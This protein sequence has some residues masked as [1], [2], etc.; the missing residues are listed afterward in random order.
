M[1]E[2]NERVIITPASMILL[3]KAGMI[4]DV[5]MHIGKIVIT[6][7]TKKITVDMGMKNKKIDAF[8]QKKMINSGDIEVTKVDLEKVKELEQKY[9]IDE[10]DSSSIVAFQKLNAKEII[11]DEKRMMDICKTLGIPYSGSLATVIIMQRKGGINK[12]KAKSMIV[13]LSEVGYYST[14]LIEY[15]LATIS[16]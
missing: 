14:L 11:V 9:G 1:S 5:N 8:E 12:E 16:S 7:Q 2:I 4:K 13:K 10:V 15:A 3:T 6:E